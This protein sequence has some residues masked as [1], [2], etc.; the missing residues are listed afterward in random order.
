MPFT[1]SHPAAVLPVHSR[2]K[3]WIPLS[4]L[5]VGSLVPDAEYYLPMPEHFRHTSHTLLGTFS[6]SLPLAIFVL[7]ILYWLAAPL[8][9]LLPSPHREALQ[10]QLKPPPASL[11]QA[12]AVIVG[13]LIG[14]WSHVLWDWCTHINGWLVKRVPL[15]QRPLFG[16][17]V[18]AY[19][20]LQYL[21]SVL[22]LY[23]LLYAYNKWMKT[24][25][26]QFSPWPERS[27]RLY[28]WLGVVAVC[29]LAAT[30]EIHEMHAITAAHWLQSRHFLLVVFTTF[31]RDML[32]AV[33]AMAIGAKML[34][35]GSSA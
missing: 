19:Q 34:R 30:I 26:F 1:F 5:V 33:C 9:F 17:S 14:A 8:V 28:L 11:Q 2:F 16:T 23:V 27:W 6:S 3:R 32:I 20:A 29:I 12:L 22:G 35:L 18:L 10:T 7:L 21:S 4:A 31:V 15:L 25:G 24:S 13:I